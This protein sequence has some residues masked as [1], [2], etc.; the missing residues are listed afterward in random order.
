MSEPAP[1]KSQE[2]LEGIWHGY[3]LDQ[4]EEMG[5]RYQPA[6][7]ATGTSS[8]KAPKPEEL[9]EL[10][11]LKVIGF[12][13][14]GGMGAVYLAEQIF[15]LSSKKSS[16][17]VTDAMDPEEQT[18]GRGR[19]VA[20]K[21]LAPNLAKTPRF[22]ERFSEEMC[23][24]ASLKHPDFVQI[25]DWDISS[26]GYH[27]F[28]MEY[29][30]GGSLHDLLHK[31]GPLQPR[32][33]LYLAG[34]ILQA[35]EFAHEADEQKCHVKDKKVIVHCDLSLKNIFLT[36]GAKITDRK[37]KIG[38]LGLAMVLAREQVQSADPTR[39]TE[40]DLEEWGA[41]DA[42]TVV[43]QIS[44]G[45]PP[46]AAPE[47]RRGISTPQSDIHALGVIFYCMLAGFPLPRSVRAEG[48]LPHMHGFGEIIT[49]ATQY[50]PAAR[51]RS[52]AE[53]NRELDS[54]R[55]SLAPQPEP[56]PPGEPVAKD[57]A[58]PIRI[59]PFFVRLPWLR[60][61]LPLLLLGV[62]FAIFFAVK[63]DAPSL[64]GVPPTPPAHTLAAPEPEKEPGP[65][66]AISTPMPGAEQPPGPVIANVLPKEEPPSRPA[67]PV[68]EPIPPPEKPLDAAIPLFDEA[69]RTGWRQDGSGSLTFASGIAT[70][71]GG[72]GHHW[73]GART[74]T[75][76]TL[77][78][79]FRLPR[80][81]ARCAIYL[82]FA[83]PGINPKS[84]NSEGC[85]VTISGSGTGTLFDQE[86]PTVAAPLRDDWNQL[87]IKAVGHRFIVTVNGTIVNDFTN[88]QYR[89]NHSEGYLGFHTDGGG[90]VEFRDLR[91][92]DLRP[93][94]L[95]DQPRAFDPIVGPWRFSNRTVRT[96][97]P[98]GTAHDPGAGPLLWWREGRSRYLLT[99]QDG[100]PDGQLDL[101]EEGT[102]LQGLNANGR[103]WE[104]WRIAP[105]YPP[106]ATPESIVESADIADFRQRLLGAR[107]QYHDNWKLRESDRGYPAGPLNF[108]DDGTWHSQWRWHYW[109]V[110]RRTVHIQFW[111]PIYKPGTACVLT[112]DEALTSFSCPHPD[113][114]AW[115]TGQRLD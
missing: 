47:Q 91:V 28:V 93:P 101:N 111:D 27:Y 14:Q 86:P 3:C 74:F 59:P 40:T 114:S 50:R 89:V 90:P 21:V 76:F 39:P 103:A 41:G 51:Y 1:T 43:S 35:I 100:T 7:A 78:V 44:V 9:G 58:E 70:A 4:M 60:Y 108:F 42:V 45:T 65:T 99:R 71:S 75:D 33:A 49:H 46:F 8:W 13:G 83:K 57:Q 31:E 104:A 55:S 16:E 61:A 29:V 19:L 34:L 25:Y 63:K 95:Y 82:R 54:L 2:M 26:K 69:H 88:R 56:T 97:L 105:P 23:T 12:L 92:Q 36:P 102:Y 81:D 64:A 22:L 77:S 72:F 30:E 96:F 112:F 85:S 17:G 5:R 48:T 53:I 113:G 107:W 18:V 94:P 52:V 109:I 80:P 79:A 20:V 66:I 73:Y 98:D 106:D 62:A 115:L 110:D 32:D 68:S 11:N 84:I 67:K 38:D 87:E 10:R 24:Q 15:R 6:Q 37:I